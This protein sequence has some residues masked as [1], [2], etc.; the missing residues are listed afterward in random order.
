MKTQIVKGGLLL[1]L[2]SLGLMGCSKLEQK[3]DA[4]APVP[5]NK[6]DLINVESEQIKNIATA[7]NNGFRSDATIPVNVDFFCR[8]H[9]TTT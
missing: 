7:G 3:R 6:G 4:E 9:S 1:Y 5:Y 8:W 2:T